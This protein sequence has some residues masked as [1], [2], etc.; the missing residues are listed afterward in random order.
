MKGGLRGKPDLLPVVCALG[1]GYTEDPLAELRVWVKEPEGDDTMGETLRDILVAGGDMIVG[2]AVLAAL[3]GLALLLAATG[4]AVAETGLAVASTKLLSEHGSTRSTRYAVSNK[5]VTLDGKTHVAWLDSISQTM[6]ATYDHATDTWGDAVKVGDGKDNHGGPALTCDGEGH[7]HI[8]FGPHG[9]PFQHCR[10][11]KPNDASEW[12]KRPNF[13]DNGTYPSLVCDRDDTLHIIYRGGSSPCKLL[14]QQR[15]KDGEW[16]TPRV[17]ADPDMKPGYTHYHSALTIAPDD[18]LHVS[19]DIYRF[20]AAKGAGHMMSRDRGETW[21]LADGSPLDLPVMPASEVFFRRT[22]DALKTVAIVC[23]A[24]GHPWIT[25]TPSELW[26][27]D[28]ETWHCIEPGKRV[29]PPIDL[30]QLGA[31]GPPSMDA[32]GRVYVTATLAGDV[33][34]FYSEDRG[35]SFRV[36]NVFPRDEKLPHTGLSIERPTGHNSVGVPWL[37][38][39]TGE[40][41]P[42]CYGEG[43][44][45]FVRALR[46]TQR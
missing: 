2:R 10:S 7:L 44:Y 43:I 36:V 30:A 24:Q 34:L 26:H 17:L 14:Y 13:G 41:G 29:S 5:I 20:G 25:V 1:I 12:V 8:V 31:W 11:A 38:F 33:V 28:G 3:T 27:H 18:T 9:G 35:A 42:D 37:L 23:D 39:A 32:Q 46:L 16:S 40:K 21:T 22:E 4:P 6:I 45:Q 15:P 19:F